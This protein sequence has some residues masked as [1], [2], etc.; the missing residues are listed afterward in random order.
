[1]KAKSIKNRKTA[2]RIKAVIDEE[3][4]KKLRSYQRH[5]NKSAI[6]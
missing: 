3:D 5:R 1:M 4:K 2:R 6:K